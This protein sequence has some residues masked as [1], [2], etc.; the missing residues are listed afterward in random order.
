MRLTSISLNLD[1][2]FAPYLYNYTLSVDT[3]VF[4]QNLQYAHIIIHSSF[5]KQ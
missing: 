3:M 1:L 2:M 5:K 4:R